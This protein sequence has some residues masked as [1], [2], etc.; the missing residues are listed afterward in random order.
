M[1]RRTF[2]GISALTLAGCGSE[3]PEV[4]MDYE[5]H[6]SPVRDSRSV[7]NVN[8]SESWTPTITF[9]GTNG[10]ITYTTQ[11]GRYVRTANL[12]WV[13]FDIQLSSKGTVTGGLNL[14]FINDLP[15]LSAPVNIAFVNTGSISWENMT[16]SFVNVSGRVQPSYRVVTLT[17]A[18]AASTGNN[19]AIV[20]ADF[21]NTTRLWGQFSYLV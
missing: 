20:Y 16:T 5:L 3:V 4:E 2:C 17:G 19:T 8:V 9:T 18:T 1:D 15:Y 14:S 21:S 6:P 7:A 12:V 10:D 13:C 11:N